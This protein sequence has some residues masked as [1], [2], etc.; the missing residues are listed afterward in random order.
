MF[1]SNH[2]SLLPNSAE[3]TALFNKLK[4]QREELWAAK[5]NK[6]IA[7]M[8]KAGLQN[9]IET[10][11]ALIAKEKKEAESSSSGA[12]TNAASSGTTSG[13]ASGDAQGPVV[14]K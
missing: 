2:L 8:R 7:G 12:A 6:E 3:V 4:Q 13:S 14:A 11:E 9:D 5:F 10:L 1:L